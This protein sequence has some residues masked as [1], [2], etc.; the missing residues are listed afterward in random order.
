MVDQVT[1]IR[2]QKIQYIFSRVA[3]YTNDTYILREKNY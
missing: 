2:E 1:E 3:F